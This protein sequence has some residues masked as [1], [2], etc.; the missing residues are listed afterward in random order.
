MSCLVTFKVSLRTLG[1][2]HARS[3]A[4]DEIESSCYF[5]VSFIDQCPFY[6]SCS[7]LGSREPRAHNFIDRIVFVA[8]PQPAQFSRNSAR[9]PALA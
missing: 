8:A 1:T 6:T 9:L 5:S 3:F 2:T 7:G 4:A